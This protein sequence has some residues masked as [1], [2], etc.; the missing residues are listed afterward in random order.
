MRIRKLR[1][2]L[3]PLNS[4]LKPKLLSG[5]NW[6][7][8]CSPC[9]PFC[10]TSQCPTICKQA[11]STN[12]KLTD[13]SQSQCPTICKQTISTTVLTISQLTCLK[14]Q[15]PAICKQTISTICK[16][17]LSTNNKLPDL[18]QKSVPYNISIFT[19]FIMLLYFLLF[20]S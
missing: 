10:L 19:V 16:Q 8:S 3:N 17:T 9:R 4:K 6:R 11:I 20:T 13:L 5:F 18:S 12:N 2:E 14:S 1:N 15:C 7:N